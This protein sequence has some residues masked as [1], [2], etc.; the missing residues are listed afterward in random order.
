MRFTPPYDR[1]MAESPTVG[2]RVPATAKAALHSIAAGRHQTVADFVR[3]AISHYL[4][5]PH[6]APSSAST[7]T[8][9]DLIGES[10]S[11]RKDL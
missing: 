8:G 4:D 9:G 3:D 5:C 2:V 7:N 1:Q 11:N 10:H 6:R